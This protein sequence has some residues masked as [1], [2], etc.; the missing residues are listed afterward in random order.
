MNR[1]MNRTT[2]NTA[3]Q[4]YYRAIGSYRQ[5]DMGFTI[6]N[7]VHVTGGG[8]KHQARIK[9]RTDTPAN[10]LVPLIH[11]QPSS[12]ESQQVDILGWALVHMQHTVLQQPLDKHCV[13]VCKDPKRKTQRQR[14]TQ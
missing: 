4:T 9:G 7:V 8:Q 2:V 1:H 12:T 14:P 5:Q 3:D 10:I 6:V 11:I 13:T